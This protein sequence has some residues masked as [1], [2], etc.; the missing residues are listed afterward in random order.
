M[1]NQ[2]LFNAWLEKF[3][4]LLPLL[5]IINKEEENIIMFDCCLIETTYPRL[6]S[7]AV[8]FALDEIIGSRLNP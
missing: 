1:F 6:S 7:A 8:C 2:T 3:I 4:P 5:T